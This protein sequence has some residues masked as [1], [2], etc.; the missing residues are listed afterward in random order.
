[1]CC[2]QVIHWCKPGDNTL[3]A[4]VSGAIGAS[5]FSF[6]YLIAPM[7]ILT[8]L[9]TTAVAPFWYG[10]LYMWIPLVLSAIL[11]VTPSIY[12]LQ[13]I[14]LRHFKLAEVHF[15]QSESVLDMLLFIGLTDGSAE[16]VEAFGWEVLQQT[17]GT[18]LH[19]TLY[20]YSIC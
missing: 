2:P 1:M 4:N 3:F 15:H 17:S 10:T 7:W 19:A 16:I 5:I 11:P 20:A 14:A 8:A 6:V 12:L 13:V 9:I 18:L